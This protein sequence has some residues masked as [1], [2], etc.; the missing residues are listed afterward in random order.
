MDPEIFA[1]LLILTLITGSL[2]ALLIIMGDY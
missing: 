1:M 2:L